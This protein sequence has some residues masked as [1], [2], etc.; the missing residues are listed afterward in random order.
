[1]ADSKETRISTRFM[2][3]AMSNL[4]PK[5]TGVEG[6]VLWVS[7]G[8][9][10][11]HDIVHGPRLKVRLG[12]KITTEGL[13]AAISVT[14]SK[15]PKVLGK[16]PGK[17]KSQVTRFV[18]ENHDVLLEYWNGDLDTKEMLDSLKRLGE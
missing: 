4:R 13:D 6:V 11:G 5:T 1:M 12:E 9:F 2:K 17:V 18:K 14:V 7:A 3:E 15:S 8:E 16:L 10:A